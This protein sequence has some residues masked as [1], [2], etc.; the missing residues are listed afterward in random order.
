MVVH[1]LR[2]G[3]RVGVTAQ[4]HAA[5]QNFLDAIEE[6]AHEIGF[7]FSGVYKGDGYASEY[8]LVDCVDD[9]AETER[10]QYTLL[11]GTAWRSHASSIATV[12]TC[13]STTRPAN[14]ALANAAAVALSA[15]GVVLLGDPQQLPQVT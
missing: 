1:A 14:F 5:I 7:V 15:R 9:N 8:D 10:D 2:A 11:A 13:C 4:S 6:R 3:L 12:S